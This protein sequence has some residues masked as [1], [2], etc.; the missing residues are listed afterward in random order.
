MTR[1]EKWLRRQNSLRLAQLLNKGFPM[2]GVSSRKPISEGE[3]TSI[4]C[5]LQERDWKDERRKNRYGSEE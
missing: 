2:D 3:R 4:L 5:I 1:R